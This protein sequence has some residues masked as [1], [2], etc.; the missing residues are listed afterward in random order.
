MPPIGGFNN[1][2][3]LYLF[4]MKDYGNAPTELTDWNTIFLDR[5]GT[6]RSAIWD[7]DPDYEPTVFLCFLGPFMSTFDLTPEE[8]M[9]YDCPF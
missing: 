7:G 3:S 9:D 2:C 5:T 8:M 4:D 6:Y 1:W